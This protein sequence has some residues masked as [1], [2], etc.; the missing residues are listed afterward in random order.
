MLA[1]KDNDWIIDL[2]ASSHMTG[3]RDLFTHLSQ[4]SDINSVSIADGRSCP[5]AGEGAVH[6]S[7]QITLEKILFVLIPVNLLSI[8]PFRIY[9]RRGGLV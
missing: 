2:R 8:V 3:T 6:A 9:R 4:L 1:S 5:I 7:S